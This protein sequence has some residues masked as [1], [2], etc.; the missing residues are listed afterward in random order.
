MSGSLERR[1]RR[2]VR[3]LPGWYRAQWEEDMVAA[4]L[5]SWLT[6]DAETDAWVLEIGKPD[7]A[8]IASVVGLAVRLYLGGAT[9]PRRYFAWGQAVRN[10]V[11]AVLLLH[12]VA[13]LDVLVRSAWSSRLFGLPA[14]PASLMTDSPGGVWAMVYDAVNFGWIAIFVTL[15]R[16][17]YRA[18]RV[19][20][21]LAIVP[22]L[23]ALLQGQVTGFMPAPFGS[24]A[25][26][27]LL[28][29]AP[30][31]AMAAFHRDAP[32]AVRAP[33]LLALPG[34][35][36]LLYV[37][38]L[39]LQVTGNTAWLPDTAGVYCLLLAAACLWRTPWIRYR[40]GAGSGVWSLALV[41][42][43]ADA[44]AFR[45]ATLSNYAHDPHLITV[46]LA[47]LLILLIA[48]AL[49]VP[50]AA[51]AQAATPAPPPYLRTTAA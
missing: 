41:L 49:V 30:V 35:Y 26:W 23:V 1:Y 16:G 33:W 46:S 18:A 51:R 8:E 21:V 13:A 42:L 45:L 37:P 14:P 34:G 7:R 27:V 32:S 3:L 25:F 20:A 10:A 5:D 36:L 29:L 12:A 11:L 4:F 50:D 19:L 17:N 40:R 31:L 22:D 28:S 6:G 24:W 2:V 15:A 48:V 43:A 47:E 44:G 9:A 38:V 39:T